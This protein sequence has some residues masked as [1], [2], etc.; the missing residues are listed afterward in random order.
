MQNIA[1]I[2]DRHRRAF[3]VAGLGLSALVL[4]SCGGEDEED[5]AEAVVEETV[6]TE[7][8]TEADEA[9]IVATAAVGAADSPAAS[10]TDVTIILPEGTA[11]AAAT[12]EISPEA[13]PDVRGGAVEIA[14]P[15]ASPVV[16]G[17]PSDRETPM[18]SPM[19]ATPVASSALATPQAT[20]GT[21][22]G[23][24]NCWNEDPSMVAGYPQW[25]SAPEMAIDPSRTYIATIETNRGTIVAELFAEQAP[26][27]VNNFVCLAVQDYYEGVPFH[28]VIRG[29]MIQTGDPT[30]TGQGGPGYQIEDELPG[31]DLDYQ[32][33]VL[34]M[35][36]A[37]PNT[38]GSQFFINQV[39]NTGRLEKNYTI[40]GR[41][42]E[43]M[44]V[45]NAIAEV[46]VKAGPA[47]EPSVPAAAMTVL[48]VEITEK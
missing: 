22:V 18:A 17:L 31:N 3:T 36:N 46:P 5:P 4:V 43:G 25:S 37:G 27:T 38:N 32:E 40:F 41:V 16:A 39:N 20:N 15:D 24:L 48:S 7:A 6:A 10:P 44:D 29:F 30:G 2:L 35:A 23:N 33:G 12:P 9:T 1:D 19:G 13:T 26:N 47:G 45:V 11:D 42:I 14:T 21:P 28:R 34:A 8:P